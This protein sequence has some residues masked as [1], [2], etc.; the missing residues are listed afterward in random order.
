M[1]GR[2]PMQPTLLGDMPMPNVMPTTIPGQGPLMTPSQPSHMMPGY[3]YPH[4][5][6][7]PP[8][9]AA[10]AMHAQMLVIA[11]ANGRDAPPT[12]LVPPTPYNGIPIHQPNVYVP[13]QLSRRTKM[14]IGAVAL[15]L[16]AAV[17][18]VAIIKGASKSGVA[19]DIVVPASTTPPP[20]AA[21]S[22]TTVVPIKDNKEA[23]TASDDAAKTK[24]ADDAA[25]LKKAADD[26]AAKTA[27]D[28]Q[29]KHDE[30]ARLKKAAD[31]KRVFE[32]QEAARKRDEQ[33]RRDELARRDEE[34]RAKK[35]ADD[36]RIADQQEARRKAAEEAARKADDRR[37]A[38][39]EE[40]ARKAD[41][42]K[43]AAAEEAAR[44]AD[45]KKRT[46]VASVD[47][48]PHTNKG[49][50][51]DSVAHAKNEAN[52]AYRA[53]NFQQAANILR[54]AVAGASNDDTTDL[55]S[56]ARSYEQFGKAYNNGM[57]PGA[58]ANEAFPQ[59][60]TAVNFDAGIGGSYTGEIRQR[61]GEVA[62]A[63]AVFFFTH[64][65]YKDALAAVQTA[66]SLNA[67]NS[68]TQTVRGKLE[69]EAN[70]LYNE[71]NSEAQ[72]NTPDAKEKLIRIK[73]MLEA[74]SSTYQKASK[75]LA[76][77]P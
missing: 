12:A 23:T 8:Q 53:K 16:F 29:A 45:D 31:D 52:N 40:A 56:L 73:D 36:K 63:A 6:D 75:L 3:G 10:S 1:A 14:V 9:S 70:R 76:S 25:R 50:S 62:P 7:M 34:A 46:T 5:A 60:R 48:T 54:A 69:S 37:K 15:T 13:P 59:L 77:L 11:S 42:R 39:A 24:A 58:K 2:G 57:S 33:I 43:K 65:S 32:A 66:E 21:A 20:A 49:G 28:E 67:S 19:E 38:A 51:S 26:A 17:A 61:L 35:A 4:L 74:K 68:T 44:K 55:K 30:D 72:T 41:D 22:K 27:G 18:T 71:A 47:V 64:K